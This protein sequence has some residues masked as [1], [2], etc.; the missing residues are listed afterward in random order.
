MI[1]I[2]FMSH[3]GRAFHSNDRSFVHVYEQK[4][5]IVKFRT[6]KIIYYMAESVSGKDRAKNPA[7]WLASQM[8]GLMGT[9]LP[10]GISRL[11][12]QKMFS[13]HGHTIN[14]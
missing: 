2:W 6:D 14:P 8:D 12:Q 1:C 5:I 11:I 10:L 13:K 7:F 9:S 4:I 3:L